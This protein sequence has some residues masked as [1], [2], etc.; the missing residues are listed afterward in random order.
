MGFLSYLIKKHDALLIPDKKNIYLC[1]CLPLKER[2]RVKQK[3]SSAGA[4]PCDRARTVTSC[5]S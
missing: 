1:A 5:D 4:P 3:V 2:V